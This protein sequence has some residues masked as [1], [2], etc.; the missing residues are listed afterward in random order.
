MRV[1]VGQRR[2]APQVRKCGCAGVVGQCTRAPQ[3]GARVHWPTTPHTHTC[4]PEL[5]V[6]A[7]RPHSTPSLAHSGAKLFNL[8]IG[9]LINF[10][11]GW[12]LG[13]PLPLGR[14]LAPP[15]TRPPLGVR[16]RVLRRYVF[17]ICFRVGWG[18]AP[19]PSLGWGLAY[20]VLR[21]QVF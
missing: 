20:R 19:R 8:R 4:A 9:Y 12:G 3:W 15:P 14:G 10:R 5:R 17:L 21:T 1:V 11:V 13:P 16:F 6:A 2:R 7:A 18:S